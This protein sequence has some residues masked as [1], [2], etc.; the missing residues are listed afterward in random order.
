MVLVGVSLSDLFHS[1]I[2]YVIKIILYLNLI[3][4]ALKI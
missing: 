3:N 1:V 4:S 2:D